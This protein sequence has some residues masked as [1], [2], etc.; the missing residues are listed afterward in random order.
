MRFCIMLEE[1]GF[2]WGGYLSVKEK[3]CRY[4]SAAP[5]RPYGNFVVVVYG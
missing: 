2:L 3:C 4:R 5:P 1:V